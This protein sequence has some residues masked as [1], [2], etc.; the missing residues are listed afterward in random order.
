MNKHVIFMIIISNIYLSYKF[1]PAFRNEIKETIKADY[2][3]VDTELFV[4]KIERNF[5]L[6]SQ[7]LISFKTKLGSYKK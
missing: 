4:D 6:N 3:Q 5:Y 7:Y 2:P 1:E